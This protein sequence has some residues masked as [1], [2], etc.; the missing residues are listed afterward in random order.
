MIYSQIGL[1]I[2]MTSKTGCSKKH[3]QKT[4]PVQEG[5]HIKPSQAFACCQDKQSDGVVQQHG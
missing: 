4:A 3:L 5:I 2:P 1:Y